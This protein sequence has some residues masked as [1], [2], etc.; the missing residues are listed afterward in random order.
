M[1]M[2][3]VIV[4]VGFRSVAFVDKDVQAYEGDE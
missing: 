1:W 4:T 2:A 3:S